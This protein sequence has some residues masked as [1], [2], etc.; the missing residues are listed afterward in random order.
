MLERSP[1]VKVLVLFGADRGESTSI[2]LPQRT[3]VT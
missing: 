2:V 3:T 1:L